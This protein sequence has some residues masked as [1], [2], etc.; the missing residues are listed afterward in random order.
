MGP[1]PL[2]SLKKRELP[3]SLLNLRMEAQMAIYRRKIR[4]GADKGVPAQQEEH[5]YLLPL[6]LGYLPLLHRSRAR[7]AAELEPTSCRHQAPRVAQAVF[8]W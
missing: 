4:T 6:R 2:P 1:C 3:N 8:S 7:L 5:L